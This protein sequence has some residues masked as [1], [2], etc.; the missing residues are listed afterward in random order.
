[1]WNDRY[2]HI[3]SNHGDYSLYS[4]KTFVVSL[5]SDEH[6]SDFIVWES[7]PFIP[8]RR[9]SNRAPYSMDVRMYY[10]TCYVIANAEKHEDNLHI[11]AYTYRRISS[12]R[13]FPV[14]FCPVNGIVMTFLAF[15]L[16]FYPS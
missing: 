11:H 15:V 3:D 14:G 16:L 5:L 2:L 13:L 6:V 7:P 12:Y 10:A 4:K 1:M 8:F 9:E